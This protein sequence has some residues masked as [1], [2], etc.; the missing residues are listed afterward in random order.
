MIGKLIN[1]FLILI[2]IAAVILILYRYSKKAANYVDEEEIEVKN[3]FEMDHI[4][5][6]IAQAFQQILKT[7]VREQN[8]SRK[9][10]L[11]FNAKR[12]KIR[13]VQKTSAFGDIKAKRQ[14]MAY[15]KDIVTSDN[16]FN[17][18][19]KTIDN[20]IPFS[21]EPEKMSGNDKFLIISM[22]Y[23]KE[24]GAD[25]IVKW[26]DEFGLSKQEEITSDDLNYPYRNTIDKIFKDSC[27][28]MTYND[29][30]DIF[31]QRA[32]ERYK[33][34]GTA[35]IL[36][37]ST[38]DEVEGGVSGIP[39][40]GISVSN[41]EAKSIPYSYQSIWVIVHGR[42]IHLSCLSFGSQEELVR[43]CNNIYK[44]SP[45]RALSKASG[46]VVTT[47]Y[48]GSRVVD[49]RPDFADSY[50]FLVRKFDS[51]KSI[52]PEELLKS[53]QQNEIAI[54]LIKWLVR[55][56]RNI[57]VT[58]EQGCGKSTFLKSII[59]FIPKSLALRI[60][61]L[62]F[63]LALR[64]AY[65][66][67][68]I[69]SFQER[70]SISAQEGLNLQKKTSGDVNV[71]GE[72]ATAEQAE[73][74]IQTSRVASLFAL[75]THHAKTSAALVKA[76]ANNLM[77]QH[78]CSNMSDAISQVADVVDIDIHL[79]NIK[80]DRHIERI[81]EIILLDDPTYPSDTDTNLENPQHADAKEFYKRMTDRQAFKTVDLIQCIGER[82]VLKNIPSEKM[83]E[84]IKK[85]LTDD[86]EIEFEKDMAR[87]QELER[88]AQ[89]EIEVAS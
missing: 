28:R 10:V 3:I 83:I 42:K 13:K 16:S 19:S 86:E 50:A 43:V 12:S 63:E 73:H 1:I 38:I 6:R 79:V 46:Y 72:I 29:K 2:I 47:M 57:I 4:V 67:R 61:E 49:V 58:G 51:A 31:A 22:L 33:G 7:N 5:R 66:M 9:Q 68:N 24:F 69:L 53:K 80:G 36:F 44:F 71:I 59:R 40:D 64:F 54:L 65:P 84:E 8:L 74:Y 60:Q 52:A 70:G 23:M 48:N 15:I 45:S 39:K 56:Y 41:G 89:A 81:T 75:A 27:G 20:I 37:E 88:Q 26:L 18:N 17:I 82:Y 21:E 25:G 85:K 30:L 78:I 32:F 34:F 62:S 76:L 14:I 11:E 55:G 77:T 87:I 35:D